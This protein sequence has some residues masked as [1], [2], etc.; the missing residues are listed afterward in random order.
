VALRGPLVGGFQVKN[1]PLGNLPCY[2]R[3][4]FVVESLANTV[5]YFAFA[6]MGAAY[7]KSTP[8][9]KVPVTR[10]LYDEPFPQGL[11]SWH[12]HLLSGEAGTRS[13]VLTR[14]CRNCQIASL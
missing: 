4:K 8:L 13:A 3:G 5:W 10:I 9:S 12:V 2:P 7:T 14:R 6:D 1:I 11:C